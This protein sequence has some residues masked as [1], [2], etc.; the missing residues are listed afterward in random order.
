MI[1]LFLILINFYI[2][3]ILFLLVI[4]IIFLLKH[5]YFASYIL[6]MDGTIIIL[7]LSYHLYS[8]V[9]SGFHSI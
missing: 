2:P 6:L 7:I 4:S 8:V 3:I 5:L 9:Q 1:E